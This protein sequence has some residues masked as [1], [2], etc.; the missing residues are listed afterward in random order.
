MTAEF[1]QEITFHKYL[2]NAS[3]TGEPFEIFI[4]IR[5][6]LNY[7]WDQINSHK[8]LSY[9]EGI[10]DIYGIS[11]DP[12]TKNYVMVMRY[13]SGGDMRQY[14]KIANKQL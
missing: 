7:D 10:V 12:K 3:E 5:D 2:F 8:Q 11:Q 13:I 1:L 4:D 9:A 6:C 14:S